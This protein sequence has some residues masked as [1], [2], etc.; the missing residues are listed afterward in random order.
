[1]SDCVGEEVVAGL[2]AAGIAK[3][4]RLGCWRRMLLN[5]DREEDALSESINCVKQRNIKNGTLIA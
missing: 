2:R 1:M 3:R 4:L 5:L